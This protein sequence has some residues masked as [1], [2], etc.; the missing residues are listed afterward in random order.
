MFV[1]VSVC[2]CVCC[3]Y[4]HLNYTYSSLSKVGEFG[5]SR[6]LSNA[7]HYIS[8]GGKIPVRWTAPEAM[9]YQKY[10]TTSDIWSYGCLLYEIWS[11]GRM[12]FREFT[13]A[14]VGIVLNG[15]QQ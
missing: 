13:N 12:P 4:L 15:D 1:C 10:S 3:K 11:L 8:S 14:E 5:K 6:D 2:V 9:Y 7:S